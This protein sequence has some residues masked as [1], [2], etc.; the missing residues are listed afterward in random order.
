MYVCC[1]CGGPIKDDGKEIADTRISHGI[2]DKCTKL[3]DSERDKLA[4]SRTREREAKN[5]SKTVQR[6]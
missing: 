1:F 5:D 6:P 4:E 3:T 2:C